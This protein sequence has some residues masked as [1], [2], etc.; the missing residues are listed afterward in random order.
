MALAPCSTDPG[1]ALS[2]LPSPSVTSSSREAARLRSPWSGSSRQSLELFQYG[3]RSSAHSKILLEYTQAWQRGESPEIEPYLE[4]LPSN[5]SAFAIDL[6]YRDYCLRE[7][8]GN[9]PDPSSYLS[10]FPDH[11][12]LLSDLFAM[13]QKMPLSQLRDLA[14]GAWAGATTAAT[15]IEFPEPGDEIGPFRLCRMLG[16]GAF[17]RVFLAE[18]TNLGDR[19]VVVKISAR[20]S[21]EPWLLAR[22]RHP[23]IVEIVSQADVEDGE[24]QLICM[25]FLGGTTLAALFQAD[26]ERA[27][28]WPA[29]LGRDFLARLDEAA[30]PGSPVAHPARPAREILAGLTYSQTLA[31]VTARLADALGHAFNCDVIHGD[32]KP[33]NILVT[34][35]A[36]PMLLDFNLAQDWAGAD[37]E[38]D[39]RDLGGTLLYMAPERLRALAESVALAETVWRDRISMSISGVGP[40]RD[41]TDSHRA[42]IYSLGVVLIEAL[43]GCHPT[44]LT[45]AT[46]LA[47]SR[48]VDR[49]ATGRNSNAA[50][51]AEAADRR[52]AESREWIEAVLDKVCPALRSILWKC[53][54]PDPSQ[55]YGHAAELAA[56]LDRWRADRPLLF[57]PEPSRRYQLARW[58]RRTRRPLAAVGFSLV[59]GLVA[60]FVVSTQS[61]RI[62]ELAEAKFNHLLDDPEVGT[63]RF[64]HRDIA[65][66]ESR[67]LDDPE[68]YEVSAR[69]LKDYRIFEPGDWRQAEDFRNLPVSQRDELELWLMERV[70]RYCVAL[71]ERPDSPAD[72]ERA[73]ETLEHVVE[74][75]PSRAFSI[76]R[77]RLVRKLA[78]PI[79][80]TR[81]VAGELS[82]D[83]LNVMSGSPA[84]EEYL[85][86]VAAECGLTTAGSTVEVVDGVASDRRALEHYR[87]FLRLQPNS[88]WGHYRS[89]VITYRLGQ[90]E[91][92]VTHIERCL[93]LRPQNATLR[94]QY[95][96]CL[97]AINRL[98]RAY[99]ECNRAI[100]A[101]PDHAE[102][103]RTRVT[104]RAALGWN[105]GLR[106]D[107]NRFE[108]LR[109]DLAVGASN[110]NRLVQAPTGL[111]IVPTGLSVGGAR[112]EG[113][114]VIP[115]DMTRLPVGSA[116]RPFRRRHLVSETEL[117]ERAHVARTIF[118]R[119][120]DANLA[121]GELDKLLTLDP[122]FLHGRLMRA[123]QRLAIGQ[124][125]AAQEDLD[126]LWN[127]PRLPAFLDESPDIFDRFVDI[128]RLYL[129][130]GRAHEAWEVSRRAVEIGDRLNRP[131]GI[132]RYGLARAAA[133][134][135]ASEPEFVEKAAVALRDTFRIDDCFRD[136]YRHDRHFGAARS[137]IDA[138]LTQE[139][140]VPAPVPPAHLAAS[141]RP[142]HK[143][144]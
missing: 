64:Q 74:Y 109:G 9:A 94:G 56:D 20:A 36:N 140:T 89:A 8:A 60:T 75:E 101:D 93:A 10:R 88:L 54:D 73:L 144:P 44:S 95:V 124:I 47:R 143:H 31:W 108:L 102:Y 136:W 126:L 69:V 24:F 86:G 76:L 116:T 41:R 117:I 113:S 128:S 26:R 127:N 123:I 25:P 19:P 28:P 52:I 3:G 121:L 16:E 92:A 65:N 138:W 22:V 13:H 122:D 120:G 30:T 1:L 129:K 37:E 55:R 85:L 23:H 67:D 110:G 133:V 14:E 68:T 32:V 50:A 118:A 99:E 17:A 57:A 114:P 84:I 70:L 98:D 141:S 135:A 29:V 7:A 39:P 82:R 104:I 132:L 100:A 2:S 125:D 53:L 142:R 71:E 58:V 111:S 34:A 61:G 105:Q 38:S 11:R 42:D 139:T 33:S 78:D 72:W 131:L 45:P 4:R 43:L 137:Q 5:D 49:S 6:I 83:P 79:T 46:S 40:A 103:Y 106:E 81:G 59:A 115:T 51:L 62:A 77:D 21:S 134:R 97:V 91:D 27:L 63:F 107:I 48:Q 119:T 112:R 35:D 96:G 12:D 80:A 15:P 130:F 90:L 66:Q 87:R 18:Q